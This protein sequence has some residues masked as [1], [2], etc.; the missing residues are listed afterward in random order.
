MI[1]DTIVGGIIFGLAGNFVYK[2][3]S[4]NY[5]NDEII[6]YTT[7]SFFFICGCYK[8]YSIKNN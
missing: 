1:L 5:P 7:V 2:I 4:K 8:V 6:Y 3:T